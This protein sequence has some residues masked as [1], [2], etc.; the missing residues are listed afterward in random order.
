MTAR[1]HKMA[2]M[3]MESNKP[4]TVYDCKKRLKFES[5]VKQQMDELEKIAQMF[6]FTHIHS[7]K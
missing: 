3:E 7:Q 5:P 2:L 1:F 4:Y 6:K